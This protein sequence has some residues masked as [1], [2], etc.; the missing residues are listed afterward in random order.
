LHVKIIAGG[1]AEVV[2]LL[3]ASKKVDVNAQNGQ[4]ETPLHKVRTCPSFPP[5]NVQSTSSSALIEIHSAPS[6]SSTVAL[7]LAIGD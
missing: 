6:L 5:W 1:H 3:V 2:Q 4:G 7:S